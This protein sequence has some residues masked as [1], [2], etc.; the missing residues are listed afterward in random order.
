MKKDEINGAIYIRGAAKINNDNTDNVEVSKSIFGHP[1][2]LSTIVATI[3]NNDKR[4]N[5][6]IK[7][8]IIAYMVISATPE[9]KKE[10][11]EVL[12]TNIKNY[13]RRKK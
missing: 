6:V 3:M 11:I 5:E 1:V 4:F 10:F 12:T 2:V 8:G 13:E 7:M 9:E